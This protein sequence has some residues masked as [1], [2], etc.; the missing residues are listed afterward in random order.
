MIYG[1]GNVNKIIYCYHIH[2]GMYYTADRRF[3]IQGLIGKEVSFLAYFMI[4]A[5]GKKFPFS[6]Q[7]IGSDLMKNTDVTSYTYTRLTKM[8]VALP[9]GRYT[10]VTG[11]DN[12]IIIYI[13]QY[14]LSH[15]CV[16]IY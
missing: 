4:Q 6:V 9:R 13:S 5:P 16:A 14:Q 7:N 2:Y 3:W 10:P 12:E 15:T 8:T 1:I 11:S